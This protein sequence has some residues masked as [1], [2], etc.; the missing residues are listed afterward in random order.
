VAARFLVGVAV[1]TFGDWLTAL[2]LAVVLYEA[3]GSVVATAGYV[4][5]RFAPRP[6]GSWI[7][8]GLGD[9]V[10]QR[11]AIAGAAIVQGG[12][13]AT[14]VL[15][16][17]AGH[18]LWLIYVLAGLSQLVGGA[19]QPLTGALMARLA[20][21]DARHTL[22]FA[23][24]L[25][26]SGAMLVAPALG[27]VLLPLC[28]A[29]P[30]VLGDAATF[31]IA[32]ALFVSL[33]PQDRL[34]VPRATI[35]GAA[36]QGFLTAF[37]QPTL[38]VVATGAFSAALVITALQAILPAL[39]AER[40][41]TAANAGLCYGAVGLGGILGSLLALWRPMRRPQVIL[42][43]LLAEIAGIGAVALTGAPAADLILL[44]ASTASANLA[45]VES[46]VV[47]QSQP[48]GTVARVQGAVST[49]RYT[50]MM[51][52]AT[53]AL[54]LALKVGWPELIL[55]LTAVGLV[56]LG[57]SAFG[58]RGQGA[59]ATATPASPLGDIPD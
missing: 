1:S 46:G 20:R 28:G 56:A 52:G 30:L 24:S 42:P 48:S 59:M 10:D 44:A 51:A 53:I 18:D 37:R 40:L 2:A 39:A 27:A 14:L 45:Q 29:V 47:V 5:V 11:L 6:L 12:L 43:G 33:P 55:I 58:P 17:W 4:L 35:R 32:A 25:L 19:W 16:L 49:A 26:G 54:L 15:P 34:D 7:A 3:T 38:R 23:Y 31:V 22:N 36:F 13:T 9:R 21:G 8:G 50:G 57:G 41:G